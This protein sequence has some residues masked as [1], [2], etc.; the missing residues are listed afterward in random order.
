MKKLPLIGSF[1]ISVFFLSGCIGTNE[2]Q[3]TVESESQKNI[4]LSQ[5]EMTLPTRASE[6]N[7]VVS[8]IEGNEII[9]KKEIGKE[10]LTEEQMAQR[11]AERQKLTEVERQA[12]RASELADVKTEDTPL[13]IP[14][15]VPIY[16][17][18]GT[19]TGGL[20]KSDLS[21]IKKGTYLSIWAT[22]TGIEAVKIKGLN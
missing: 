11:K 3:I 17:A 9:I 8:S 2:D 22:E 4:L 15:G 10:S 13:T 6:I 16:K 14:V 18:D 21:E 5:D 7:G 19:G 20:L 1:L 12:L